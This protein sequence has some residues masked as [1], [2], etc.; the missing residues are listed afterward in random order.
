MICLGRFKDVLFSS[1]EGRR[2]EEQLVGI[3][4]LAMTRRPVAAWFTF[5]FRVLSVD[6]QGLIHMRAL[7]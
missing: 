6:L 1:E 4:E 2:G 5:S 3:F 7:T